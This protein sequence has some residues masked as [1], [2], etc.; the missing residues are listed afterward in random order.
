MTLDEQE[1]LKRTAKELK[2][3]GLYDE[4]EPAS[5]EKDSANLNSLILTD[6]EFKIIVEE[7]FTL[8]DSQRISFLTINV[9]PSRLI[10]E[11]MYRSL[12]LNTRIFY[13]D[14]YAQLFKNRVV[15]TNPNTDLND[16]LNATMV[17]VS[18]LTAVV[19]VPLGFILGALIF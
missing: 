2:N 10:T 6:Q 9:P 18:L 16:Y 1:L 12:L 14:E 3:Y 5:E 8:Y 15:R 13:H 4:D 7:L 17:V 11:E 19:C